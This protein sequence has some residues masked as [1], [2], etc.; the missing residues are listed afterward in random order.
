MCH[1]PQAAPIAKTLTP[2][3]RSLQCFSQNSDAVFT[4]KGRVS[5]TAGRMMTETPNPSTLYDHLLNEIEAGRDTEAVLLLAGMLDAA[6]SDAESAEKFRSA[7]LHHPLHQFLKH[8]SQHGDALARLGIERSRSTRTALG[9]LA[10]EAAWKRGKHILAY[11]CGTE[12]ELLRLAGQSQ[13]NIRIER[14]GDPFPATRH[15]LILASHLPDRWPSTQLAGQLTKLGKRL[16]QGGVL[17][18]ASLVPGH[19]GHGLRQVCAGIPLHC[20]SESDLA[21]AAN[22]AGFRLSTFRD[23][24]NSLIWAELR[25]DSKFREQCGETA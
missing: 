20:H 17:L 15:D 6:E 5:G 18:I 21:H 7:L 11:Q 4:S 24:S 16:R 3:Y 9:A 13:D 19:L 12:G 1:C 10:V 2:N 25:V 8:Q 22:L 23:A 14:A